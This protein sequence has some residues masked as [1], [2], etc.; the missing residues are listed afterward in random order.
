[1]KK[2]IKQSTLT[3]LLNLGSIFLLLVSVG[4]IITNGL[5]NSRLD[6]T[7]Q[8][9]VELVNHTSTF[10]DASSYLTN[11]VRAFAATGDQVHY[12]N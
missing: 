9:R 1:M 2:A 11:E 6:Q 5:L 8:D 10:F 7:N 12:D 3:L 4:L